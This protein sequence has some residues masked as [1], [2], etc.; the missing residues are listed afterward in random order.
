MLIISARAGTAGPGPQSRR[1][2]TRGRLS[3][4]IFTADLAARTGV[5][6]FRNSEFPVNITACFVAAGRQRLL[7]PNFTPFER[8]ATLVG[9]AITVR[10]LG[11][12]MFSPQFL[13]HRPRQYSAVI[14]AL[15]GASADIF[16]SVE[17]SVEDTALFM[18]PLTSDRHRRH[19]S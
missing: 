11:V 4:Q 13:Q 19:A 14:R 10:T 8:R 18:V 2:S 5:K 16:S 17:T 15:G 7:S 1:A 12:L 3:S 6:I 9:A